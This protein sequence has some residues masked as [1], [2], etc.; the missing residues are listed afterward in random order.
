MGSILDID[1][2]FFLDDIAHWINVDD[3]L[4]DDYYKPWTEENFRSFLEKRCLLSKERPI[5]GRILRNH[6]EAFFFWDEL[7]TSSLVNI[8]F[9]VT[10]VDA[11]SDT[12]LGDSGYVYIMQKLINQPINKRRS[13]LDISKV[14]MGN[15]LAF[16][17]AC[18]WINQV[19]FVLHESWGNDISRSHLKNY[20]E[21][22]MMFQFKSFP[23]DLNIGMYYHQ[24]IDGTIPPINVDKEIPYTLIPWK[25]YFT[26]ENFDFMVFCQ[27]PGYTPKSADFMMDII[28][29]Y[30]I[31]I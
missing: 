20:D 30:M 7:I 13:I 18:G 24:I 2:D 27:S 23:K 25:S 28:K 31:E 4:D 19:D 6:H 29:E 26:S 16:A 11:H 14:S 5:R 12:G 17:L 3:R 22:E 21:K 8:P 1:M 15:Y 10:H 9:K